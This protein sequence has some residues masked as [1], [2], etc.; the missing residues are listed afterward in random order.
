MLMAVKSERAYATVATTIIPCAFQTLGTTPEIAKE[1]VSREP[2]IIPD[3][4]PASSP[5]GNVKMLVTRPETSPVKP[6]STSI[7]F[8]VY[9]SA[10]HHL[11]GRVSHAQSFRSQGFR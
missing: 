10:N 1:P 9:S 5:A 4:N 8:A 3:M 2:K 7:L 11:R 6:K